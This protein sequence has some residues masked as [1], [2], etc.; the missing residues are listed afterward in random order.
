M[1]QHSTR[2]DRSRIDPQPSN[3]T[4]P[5]QLPLPFSGLDSGVNGPS[6]GTNAVETDLKSGP[7]SVH[8]P[9]RLRTAQRH[10]WQGHTCGLCGM[11]RD[12]GNGRFFGHSRFT[13]PDGQILRNPGDCPGNPKD[14]RR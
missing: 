1:P 3:E 2:F 8:R 4:D 12:G 9:K 11:T 10:R 14:S 5:R 6:S 13:K 7:G